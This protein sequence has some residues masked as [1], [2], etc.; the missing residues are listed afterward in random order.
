M[1]YLLHV[2]LVPICFTA[3]GE[4]PSP[5]KADWGMQGDSSWRKD[6][7]N[8]EVNKSPVNLEKLLTQPGK[9]PKLSPAPPLPFPLP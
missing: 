2:L 8:T 1:Y 6:T 4:Q 7:R 9:N 5:T 3:W